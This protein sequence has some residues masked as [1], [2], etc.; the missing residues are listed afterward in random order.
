[1]ESASEQLRI[2]LFNDDDTLDMTI[3]KQMYNIIYEFI[4]EYEELSKEKYKK[5]LKLFNKFSEGK[6]K[7]YGKE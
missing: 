4:L 5:Y 3:K 2:G 7:K 1:M 6:P